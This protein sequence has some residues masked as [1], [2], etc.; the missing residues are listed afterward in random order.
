MIEHCND[1]RSIAYKVL[2]LIGLVFFL[3]GQL[4]LTK[5]NDFV[6]EQVPIDFA[7]WFLLLGVVFLI[8][9]TV[10]YPTK[11][12]SL[13]GIPITLIGIVC[14]IG[15]CVLDFIWWSFPTTEMRNEFTNHISQVP[16]IWKPFMTIGP[17]SK[18]F[19]VGL[20]IVSLNYLKQA[21]VGIIILLI[22]NLILWHVIPL[23]FRLVIG[24]AL[25]L[26][27]FSIIFLRN[28]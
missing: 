24:Y 11:I 27:G 21:K 6:Y 10:S 23:P 26:I 15:M 5:G 14:I 3:I 17:S 1:K 22:A 25:T 18:V 2:F 16:S 28:K 8:P 19:N 13:I 9:Q 12:F 4:I 20:L 7:H